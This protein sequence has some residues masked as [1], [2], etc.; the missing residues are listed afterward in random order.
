LV[1][2][3]S[4]AVFDLNRPLCRSGISARELVNGMVYLRHRKLPSQII[5]ITQWNFL[6]MCDGRNLEDLKELAPVRLGFEVSVDQLRPTVEYLAEMGLLEGTTSTSNHHRVADA[7]RLI[8]LIAPLV[9]AATTKWFAWVTLLAS[10]SCIGLLIAD[11]HRFVDQVALAAREH[12]V[13]SI[14]LYYLTFIPIALLHEL[15]HAVVI[16]YYGGEVP[17]IVIRRNGHFAVLSNSTVLKERKQ[18]LWFLSMGSVVDIYIWLALLIAFHYTSNYLLLMLLLPQTVYVL[19]YSY[20]I[21]NNSD[22]LKIVATWLELPVPPRPWEYV[23]N[24]WRRR[25]ETK[26]ARQLV[27]T[28]TISLVIKL[29]LTAFLIW[30]FLMKE[31]RVLILYAIYKAVIY[32]IGH[33]RQWVRR[34]TRSKSNLVATTR[35]QE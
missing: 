2:E 22:F 34:F 31:H 30:T 11:W 17:E 9:R 13:A 10:F 24:G 4:P 12:P 3:T 5:N 19:V 27:Y 16:R 6:Q 20:S 26:T 25:P 21:F 32:A 1:A 23:R 15:G 14:L 8:D 29:A 18:L 7:S 35:A 28:M 33:W